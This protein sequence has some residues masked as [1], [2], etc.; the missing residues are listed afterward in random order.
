[1][2]FGHYNDTVLK[3]TK[4]IYGT[5]EAPIVYE[6]RLRKHLTDLG[7]KLIEADHNV[8]TKRQKKDIP[9]VAVSVDRFCIACSSYA[10]YSR[11]LADLRT[12]YKAKDLGPFKHLLG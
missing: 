3:V 1:M 7:Y 10:M 2:L 12:K 6:H 9:I 11:V 8:Y 4:N 5:K